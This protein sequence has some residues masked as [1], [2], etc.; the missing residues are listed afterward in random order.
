[1]S[2]IQ[3]RTMR[4]LVGS[5][6]VGGVG[7]GA[8]ASIGSLL[9]ESVTHS[10]S[11]AGVA[12]TAATLGAAAFGLPLALLA[13]KTG[14][15]NALSLGWALSAVGA[16]VLVVSA[17]TSSVVLLILGMLMFGSGS[18]TN[19]QSRYAAADLAPPMHRARSLSVVIWATTIGAVVGPNLAAP[20]AVVAGALRIPELG[21]AFVISAV[22]LA[23]AAGVLRIALRPDPLLE[24]RRHE[25][26]AE[27]RSGRK[28]AAT[29]P[30]REVFRLIAVTP[31]ARFAFVAIVLGHTIMG[32]VMTMTPVAMTSMGDSL[33]LVGLTI[34]G[35]VL[36]MYAFSPVVG[37]LADRIGRFQVILAGQGVFIAAAA[38]AGLAG[39]SIIRISVGLFLLGLGWSFALVSGSTMLGDSVDPN[40]RTAVQGTADT[41]MNIV[42][43]G[44]AGASG[45]VLSTFGFSGLNLAA[46]FLILPVLFLAPTVLRNHPSAGTNRP[47][48]PVEPAV[49]TED[50]LIDNPADSDGTAL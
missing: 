32:A 17:T 29:V 23:L 20:G 48:L 39:H 43:A 19:L 21:G 18:A 26:A 13:M 5:Q 33:T 34:S 2:S 28:P 10:E 27:L 24:A 8:A 42:S 14:R 37:W 38:F 9:A 31:N 16:V 50:T 40:V 1:M 41:A 35:H 6:I 49:V 25:A 30:M 44:A 3:R 7:V 11:Y 36:G 47:V 15:R 46:A 22:A 45:L 4:A 12:R